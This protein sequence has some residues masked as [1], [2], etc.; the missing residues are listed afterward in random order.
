MQMSA[1]YAN[2]AIGGKENSMSCVARQRNWLLVERDCNRDVSLNQRKRKVDWDSTDQRDQTVS[3]GREC[4]QIVGGVVD[5]PSTFSYASLA[6]VPHDIND[7]EDLGNGMVLVVSAEAD[8]HLSVSPAEVCC[9][10]EFLLLQKSSQQ[11]RFIPSSAVVSGQTT[12][13]VVT[14]LKQYFTHLYE[15]S[16]FPRLLK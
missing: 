7:F 5:M 2:Y 1:N 15:S 6:S 11:M 4:A 13:N 10:E 14:K 9:K 12:Y 8:D 16:S 3:N